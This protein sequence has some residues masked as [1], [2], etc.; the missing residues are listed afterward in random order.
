MHCLVKIDHSLD[1][2]FLDLII[3]DLDLVY[4]KFPLGCFGN[5]CLGRLG[6][7]FSFKDSLAPDDGLRLD[8]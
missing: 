7:M 6:F 4:L 5:S 8:F 2:P 3:I 1:D